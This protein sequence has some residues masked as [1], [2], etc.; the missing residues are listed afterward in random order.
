MPQPRRKSRRQQKKQ[1]ARASAVGALLILAL[2]LG[3]VGLI[4]Y[5]DQ[6][7]PMPQWTSVLEQNPYGPE[8]FDYLGGYLTCIS[9][10][11]RMGVDVSEYQEK[12]DW[13]QVRTAGFDFAFVRIG[14]RGYTTGAI[15]PDDR[16]WE[17][18]EG[19]RA[20]GLDVGV[21]FYAQAVDAA[22]AK[23]E[24][25]WCLD[26]LGGYALELPV[27][28][29]WEWVGTNARTGSMNRATLTECVEVF[30]RTIQNGGYEAMVYFN[31]HVANDLLELEELEEYPFW[32]AM[33]TDQMD[34]P[35]RVDVWQ[36]TENGSVPG[37]K[38]DVDIDLMFLYD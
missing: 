12:I 31:P 38:G 18:L 27:V 13:E 17:N 9:G 3:T 32:L 4:R 30:C 11:S 20:A 15:Y 7:P 35:Y 1:A 29:D 37:I 16:A 2:L 25:Q 34:F 22:E 28:Y 23:A 14:Y 24:A 21:Y 36:Y 33:Y 5:L 10:S 19:A 6:E 8:D 26:F